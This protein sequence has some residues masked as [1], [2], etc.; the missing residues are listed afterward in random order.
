MKYFLDTEFI[1]DGT[2]IDLISIGIVSESNR[3]YYA[4]N[5]ECD[6]SKA[7]DWVLENVLKPMGLDREGFNK[8]PVDSLTLANAK[9]KKQ[10]AFEVLAFVKRLPG[11]E[12]SLTY[13]DAHRLEIPEPIHFWGYYAAYDWVTLCQLFGKMIDLPKGFPMYCRDIKQLCDELGNPELPKQTS[14]EHNALA[15]ALWNKEA[16]EFLYALSKN[17]VYI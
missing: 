10:I 3:R 17:R 11:N 13:R 5:A 8:K 16:Y 15:D 14:G 4:I 7:N 9:T 12:T 6:Y 1:E 2:T